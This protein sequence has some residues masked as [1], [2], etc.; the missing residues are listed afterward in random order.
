M[1]SQRSDDNDDALVT[2]ALSNYPDY[3]K[4][5]GEYDFRMKQSERERVRLSDVSRITIAWRCSQRQTIQIQTNDVPPRPKATRDC[6]K[7]LRRPLTR[8]S[9]IAEI[10]LQFLQQHTALSIVP[11]SLN[12][13][14][15]DEDMMMN[16]TASTASGSRRELCYRQH[17]QR[18]KDRRSYVTDSDISEAT[19]TSAFVIE[20]PLDE[21]RAFSAEAGDLAQ[22]AANNTMRYTELFASVID[23]E[24]ARMEPSRASNNTRGVIRDPIDILQEQRLQQ[25]QLRRQEQENGPNPINNIYAG[26]GNLQQDEQQQ[27]RNNNEAGQRAQEMIPPVLLRRYELHI[28]PF[29]RSGTMPPFDRHVKSAIATSKEG[30]NN[31]VSALSLRNVRSKSMGHLVTIIGMIVRSSEVKPSLVVA[32]YACDACGVEVY[33]VIQNKREFMPQRTCPSPNCKQP[34]TLHLQTRASKFLK[35]QE[36]KLQELPN[37]VPMGHIPRSL[38]V[39]CRGELTRI[40][41]PGDVVTIDGVFLPQRLA[42]SGYRAMQAGLITTTYLEAQNILIHKKSYD[43]SLLDSNLSEEE[44]SRLSEQI[45]GIATGDD[46]IGKLARSIAPEIFGHEDIKRALLL[47]LV[48]GCTRTLPDGMR[49][50]GDINICLMGDPGVAKSQ[51][52]SG[53]NVYC[54]L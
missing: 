18:I 46:P 9:F 30:S 47:Q 13:D 6:R 49:I 33:Q 23:E 41:L 54:C 4:D 8:L 24:L 16:P 37:Q 29:G 25:D 19:S 14:S 31:A 3:K 27:Q 28:L 45:M 42:E 53:R 1:A 52:I 43:E 7:H 32:A 21:L 15:D 5:E 40:A 50:R 48:G 20:V 36:L 34:D 35:F 2:A 51:V 11:I 39:Y 12:D 26:N 38:S 10:F 22:R 44:G 17:L